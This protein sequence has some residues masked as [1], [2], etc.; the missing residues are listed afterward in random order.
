[1][2]KRFF[3]WLKSLLEPKEKLKVSEKV[4]LVLKKEE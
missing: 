1:M 4:V 2:L 3:R